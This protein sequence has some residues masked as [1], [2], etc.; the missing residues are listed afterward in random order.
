V[1]PYIVRIVEGDSIR[2]TA[3][4]RDVADNVLGDRPMWQSGDETIA[5]VSDSG[6]V[7]ARQPG[8]AR[9][10]VSFGILKDTVWV[11]VVPEFASVAAG[12]RHACGITTANVAYCWGDG[13]RWGAASLGGLYSPPT[14]QFLANDT[15]AIVAGWEHSCRLTLSNITY[16]WGTDQYGQRGDGAEFFGGSPRAVA[17]PESL[18]TISSSQYHVCGT[19]AADRV[20]CWGINDTGE[21][22]IWPD[23]TRGCSPHPCRKAPIEVPGVRLRTVSAGMEHTCGLDADG[24]AYCW[25]ANES[26]QL[27]VGTANDTLSP[28]LVQTPHRF[29]SIAAGHSRTCAVTI[30][31]ELYC[32]GKGDTTPA[33]VAT[34]V[35]FKSV[36]A[37]DSA[38]GISEDD[39]LY[40]WN[41]TRIPVDMVPEDSFASVSRGTRLACAVSTRGAVYCWGTTTLTGTGL[42]SRN[43]PLPI[44][45]PGPVPPLQ[46]D[47]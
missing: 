31:A 13:G 23:T 22:G 20:F 8:W 40:C 18:V 37:F 7:H 28:R 33:R 2:L 16:C 17:L 47:T 41:D 19:S 1:R 46:G 9:L 25:G 30:S 14:P 42:P 32:W 36:S 24:H 45:P 29:K 34:D 11:A 43:F 21:L 6:T 3:E 38:C 27:G 35:K 15:K 4:V 39:K 44:S 12:D 10:Q 26:G 5:T